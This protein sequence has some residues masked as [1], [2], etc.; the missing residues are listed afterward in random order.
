VDALAASSRKFDLDTSN[1]ARAKEVLAE[2]KK[3]L[4]IAQKMIQSDLFVQQGIPDEETEPRRNILAEVDAYLQG[5]G[6]EKSSEG[7]TVTAEVRNS[8]CSAEAG[9]R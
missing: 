5:N 6:E 4:D 3:R 9:R 1:L 8:G 7:P 2:V